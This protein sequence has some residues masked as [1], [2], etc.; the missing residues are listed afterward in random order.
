M[1]TLIAACDFGTT[2]V[3]SQLFNASGK[4]ISESALPVKIEQRAD[5]FAEQYIDDY[6]DG[7]LKVWQEVTRGTDKSKITAVGFSHQRCTFGLVDKNGAPLTNLVV[8]MDKRGFKYLDEIKS[9]VGSKEYY[10]ITGLPIYYIS[11]IT[12]LL[13]LR[14]NLEKFD[15]VWKIWPI[16]NYIFHQFDIC[17]DAPID[18]ATASFIGVFDSIKRIWSEE[19]I[20]ALRLPVDM[21]P[22][23]V[24]S[25][26]VIGTA[27]N[28][29]TSELLGVNPDTKFIIGGGDQQCAA[30][31]SGMISEGKSLINLGTA[32][33]LMTSVDQPIRDPNGIIPCVCHAAPNKWEMEGHTQASGI[34]LN[35]FIEEFL[36]LDP[37]AEALKGNDI[38]TMISELA[39]SAEPTANGLLFFPTLNGST[40]P[41]DFPYSTGTFLGIRQSHRREHFIRAIFEGICLENRWVIEGMNNSG[42]MIT[43]IIYSGG[44]SKSL[45]WCQLHADVLNKKIIQSRMSNAALVGAAICAGIGSGLFRDAEDGVALFSS[46]EKEHEFIPNQDYVEVYDRLYNLYESTY[47]ALMEQDVFN[48]IFDLQE[49]AASS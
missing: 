19:I 36:Q 28:G 17:A 47:A 15:D 44:G 4:I 12:K 27:E 45:F 35:R 39:G 37:G 1:D 24:Q 26:S 14:D 2:G 43:D 10:R 29:K 41:V 33:A 40:V 3:R 8:W 16:S 13:W 11:S 23:P 34:I 25:A 7:F 38:Y 48:K 6:T 32:T 21:F 22:E 42:A 30:L 18:H 9:A 49:S 20:S 31:G 46:K 5:G